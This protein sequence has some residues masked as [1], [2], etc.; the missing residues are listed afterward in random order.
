MFDGHHAPDGTLG[1]L[2]REEQERR[3]ARDLA[4]RNSHIEDG[5]HVPAQVIRDRERELLRFRVKEVLQLI[6]PE[7]GKLPLLIDGDE[8]EP[9]P[10][11]SLFSRTRLPL[12][13]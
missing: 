11:E 1:F 3:I 8:V 2:G 7:A 12:R 13:L 9:N 5:L 10:L 4:F 6:A